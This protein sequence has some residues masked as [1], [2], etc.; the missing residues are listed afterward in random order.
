[1]MNRPTRP[2]LIFVLRLWAE[3]DADHWQWRASLTPLGSEANSPLGF[4]GLDPLT[5]YLKDHMRQE[6]QA[7]E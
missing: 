4:A 3:A 2:T 1:M 7:H 6:E 5:E